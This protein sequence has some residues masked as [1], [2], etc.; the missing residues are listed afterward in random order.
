M[1]RLLL[2]LLLAPFAHSACLTMSPAGS[3]AAN[4][5]DW[6]NTLAYT[7]T[8][9]R[10]NVYF[11]ADGNYGH[12]L[13]LSTAQ[14]STTT[15]ELRKAQSYDH[16]TD[17][18]WVTG[19]MGSSQA[20]WNAPAALGNSWVIIGSGYWI[21]NGNGQNAGTAEVGCGGV[22][23]N[24]PALMTGPAPNPAAC[25]IKLDNSTCTSTANNGCDGG[26]GVM[27]G[28]GQ[29][30]TWES[31]E[32]KGQGLNSSGNNNSETYFWFASGGN[33]ANVNISHSYLHN[34]STTYFTVVSGG[35]NNGSYDHN[36]GWG[37]FDGSLN[38]GEAIQLQGSNGQSTK[39]V[40]HHNIFRDQQTNGDVVAVITGTQT[41][42]FYD[43]L[44]FC[45]TG[46]TSTTCRH[47]DGVI[48]C[49]NSQTCSAVNVYNNTFS[50]PSSCGWNIT[51]GPSTMTVK[52]NLFFNC[53]SVGRAGGTVTIDYNSYLNSSQAA[54]GAHDVSV[55][56]GAPSPFVSIG[57]GNANLTVES[58]NY[59][60]RTS[61]GAPYD[62]A[63]LYGTAFTTDRGAAQFVSNT[64]WFV[65]PDG[66]T[67][68]SS[69]VPTGQ[70]NGRADAAYP[71]S[72]TNQNCAY[73]DFRYI[74]DDD[75]GVVGLGT[76]QPAGGDTVVIRGC[77]ANANQ[78]YPSNPN[79]RIGWD[80]GVGTAG[81][82]DWCRGVGNNICTNPTITAGSSGAHTKIL[83]G[84]A[85]DHPGV[86]VPTANMV[87][88]FGGY[89][90]QLGTFNLAGT[91]WVDIVGIELTTHNKVSAGNPGA[92]GNCTK[93]GSPAFPVDCQGGT[94]PYDDYAQN[95][96]VTSNTT[97]NILFQ[98]V[99]VHGFN[100]SGFWGPIGGPITMTRVKMNFNGFAGWNFA[101]QSD[102]PNAVGSSIIA[103][104]VTANGNGCYEQYPI[105][106]AF[107]A[108]ACYDSNSGGFGDG[109][110]GQDT[111]L[112]TFTCDHCVMQY[113]TKDAFIGPH[114]Q[115]GTLTVTN[116][117][118]I[119]NMGAQMKYGSKLNATTLFQNNL[120]VMNCFRMSETLPGAPQNFAASTGMGGSYLT[121]FCRAGGD[122]WAFLTRA[123]NTN[124]YYGN[125]IIAANATMMDINCGFVDAGGVHEET[126]CGTSPLIWKDNNFLGYTDPI[127]GQQ[128]GLWFFDPGAGGS[129]VLSASFNNYF[130]VRNITPDICGT[131]NI[132]CND[133]KQQSQPA[134]PWPGSEAALDA[135]NPFGGAGNSFYLSTLSPLPGAGTTLGGLTL[136]YYGTTRSSPPSLGGVEG[137]GTVTPTVATPTASP[138]GGSYATTQSVTLASTTA[139]AAICYTIDGSIPTAVTAGTCDGLTYSTPLSVAVTTTIHTIGTKAANLNSSVGAFA[140]TIT[141]IVPTTTVS[142]KIVISGTVQF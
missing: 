107:P 41:Y 25:G 9:V 117:V 51:G 19:T 32:W 103:S 59:N 46:G 108:R 33:L 75:S 67:R 50:F 109:W 132:T 111:T 69:N 95:G 94:Q 55:A 6:N 106:N 54:I 114:A 39:D 47:N 7:G 5:S 1:R 120:F 20:L 77:T 110:S 10:G 127:L 73:K 115:V 60:G 138:V 45:S 88:L 125:T 64:L 81:V 68:F 12:S 131:N 96:F 63:D 113:N 27:H 74:W 101:D 92:G 14:S 13:N 26:N 52:N 133:P 23:N 36:Y 22:Q 134:E 24:P 122:G 89:G 62:T 140:Y 82:N 44:D 21:I 71:G 128:P 90:L 137:I 142:G 49:F 18:G 11:L 28:A 100:A 98:D 141:P 72:G 136:D 84:Y 102:T 80:A 31:V 37:I 119:G 121:N 78:V 105:I 139:G 38:H 34:A 61:L 70:C 91:Q 16:C 124:H 86:Q 97:A 2:C 15:I 66:G 4:G 58:S 112:D 57:T 126:N 130:G 42:D 118:S 3:G 30:I 40:I 83:G 116:T 35:W 17:T 8:W 99:N 135:Y 87:Q 129:L 29:N 79:C 76:W 65:R 56:S 93:G 85:Y 53:G 48:G 104:Y 123:N 43:N